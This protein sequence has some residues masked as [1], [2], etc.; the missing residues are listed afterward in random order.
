MP[1]T[2]SGEGTAPGLYVPGYIS[3][4]DSHPPLNHPECNSTR[5]RHPRRTLTLLPHMLTEITSPV[6][7]GT[8][9]ANTTTT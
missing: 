3:D 8:V 9:W 4:H 7:R 2:P 5:L 1:T 6:L